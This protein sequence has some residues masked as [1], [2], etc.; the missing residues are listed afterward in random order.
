M[1]S[2][3]RASCDADARAALPRGP[4]ALATTC[5]S[6]VLRIRSYFLGIR[7]HRNVSVGFLYV[8]KKELEPQKGGPGYRIAAAG[9][10]EPRRLCPK[11]Q[12]RYPLSSPSGRAH[13]SCL[14]LSSHS[15]SSGGHQTK[16]EL[17]EELRLIHRLDLVSTDA[18]SPTRIGIYSRWNDG[19][20]D[21]K[22]AAR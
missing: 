22:C 9:R 3:G 17:A 19:C 4:G 8:R 14:H 20:R 7:A 12:T 10:L 6:S 2:Q 18:I 1:I 13:L 5:F 15:G 21:R 11:Y 16:E